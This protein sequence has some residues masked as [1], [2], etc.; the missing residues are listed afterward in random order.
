MSL[1][2]PLPAMEEL[3]RITQREREMIDANKTMEVQKVAALV[4]AL[5]AGLSAV[6]TAVIPAIVNI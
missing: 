3:V 6:S 2:T 5:L 4:F 1:E